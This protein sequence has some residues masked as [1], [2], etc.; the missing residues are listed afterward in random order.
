MNRLEDS[1]LGA[2]VLTSRDLTRR[3]LT[4]ADARQRESHH[5]ALLAAI[6]DTLLRV[7][8]DG[9]YLEARAERRSKR[10]Y[11]PDQMVGRRVADLMPAPVAE[12]F[13]V[14]IRRAIDEGSVET[15]DDAQLSVAMARHLEARIVALAPD[16]AVAIVR[17]VSDRVTATRPLPASG[18]TP[19]RSTS[20]SWSTAATWSSST[21]WRATAGS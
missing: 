13:L 15:V 11:S 7:N 14:A 20:R 9:V 10:F 2:V 4:E 3:K 12:R 19:R 21:T 6:P 5:R 8:C 16:E 18:R 17:D 1:R